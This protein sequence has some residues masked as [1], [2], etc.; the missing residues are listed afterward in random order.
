MVTVRPR[1]VGRGAPVS[2]TAAL[3]LVLLSLHPASAATGETDRLCSHDEVRCSVQAPRLWAEG[4]TQRVGVTGRPDTSLTVRAFRLSTTRAGAVTWEPVG[5]EAEVT[6]DERGWG[7]ADL[8]LPAAPA[9]T[10]GGPLLVAAAEAEGEDLTTVLGAW[11]EL[12]TRTPELVGDEYTADKP[13]GA[14]LG[15]RLD[16]VVPGSVYAVQRQEGSAWT[17]VPAQEGAGAPDSRTTCEETRCTVSYVVPRGLS[18]GAHTFRLVDVRSGTPV[19]TWP[20]RPRAAGE[21]RE[22]PAAE[23]FPVLGVSVQGSLA[24][25]VGSDGAA[26]VRPRSRNLDVPLLDSPAA[27]P[28]GAGTHSV[29]A[30]QFVAAGIAACALA[31]VLRPG[32]LRRRR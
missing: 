7:S 23:I 30:V 22:L 4:S 28:A 24:A 20:V 26:V 12:V 32:R 11:S 9:G 16:H 27:S 17:A 25:G 29:R 14:A 2:L 8:A 19:A 10:A 15:L 21:R 3:V 6:T 31:L 18:A 1:R 5:P 13:V